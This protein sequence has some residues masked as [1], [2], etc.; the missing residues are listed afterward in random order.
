[1]TWRLITYALCYRNRDSSVAKATR[2][3]ARRSG[4]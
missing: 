4:F 2:L 1:M 3:R